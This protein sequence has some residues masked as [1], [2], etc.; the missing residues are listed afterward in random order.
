MAKKYGFHAEDLNVTTGDGY[1]LT[2]YRIN[3]NSMQ[4]SK[5][6]VFVQ[7]GVADTCAPW[8]DQSNQSLGLTLYIF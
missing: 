3:S 6:P 1:I 4:P 2:V 7:H 5:A 8:V